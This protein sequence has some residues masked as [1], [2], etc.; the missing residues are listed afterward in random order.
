MTIRILR[1]V[2]L[3][4]TI[5]IAM[6]SC[7]GRQ[8]IGPYCLAC[9]RDGRTTCF[10]VDGWEA[11]PEDEKHRYGILGVAVPDSSGGYFAVGLHD[12]GSEGF[13]D[14]TRAQELY[15]GKLPTLSQA[16]RMA[17]CH[18]EINAAIK[19]FGGD[20]DPEWLYWTAAGADSATAWYVDMNYG[21]VDTNVRCNTSR[22]RPVTSVPLP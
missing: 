5:A 16:R 15:A 20:A 1:Y 12:S 14:W 17:A 10:T 8:E 11:L 3:L 2:Y 6:A 7:G 18:R 21:L 9:I 19:A 4:L 22:I 13:I